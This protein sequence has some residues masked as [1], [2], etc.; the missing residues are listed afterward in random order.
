MDADIAQ[1]VERILG[2]DEVSGSNPDISSINKK[3]EDLRLHLFI[4]RTNLPMQNPRMRQHSHILRFAIF[5]IKQNSGAKLFNNPD[6]SSLYRCRTRE[7]VSILIFC[8]SPSFALSKTLA[9]NC[10]ASGYQ[11]ALTDAEQR[12]RSLLLLFA[13][14]SLIFV[15]FGE[16]LFNIRI[17]ALITDAEPENA[18]AFSYFALCKLSVISDVGAKLFNNPDISSHHRC[19]T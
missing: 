15:N 16:K 12:R 6:I 14:L 2:K 19:R 4:Y 7:C 1:S 9:Q 18:S 5:H 17:S 10:G 8:A 3:G 11:L 13:L